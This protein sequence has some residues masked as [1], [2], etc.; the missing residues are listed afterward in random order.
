MAGS[1]FSDVFF[2][3][4]LLLSFV[5][6]KVMLNRSSNE[7]CLMASEDGADYRLKV[8]DAFLKIRKVKIRQSIS[9]PT[10]LH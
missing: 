10:S 4:R 9:W 8:I 3:E 2:T 6:L 7:F 5:D 1:I